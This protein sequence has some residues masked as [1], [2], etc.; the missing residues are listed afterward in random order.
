MLC[1]APSVPSSFPS[2]FSSE[3]HCRD[4]LLSL[5]TRM[6]PFDIDLL[7]VLDEDWQHALATGAVEGSRSRASFPIRFMNEEGTAPIRLTIRRSTRP[8][9]G[10]QWSLIL[11]DGDD[12]TGAAHEGIG[13]EGLPQVDEG[14][15]TD[16][17]APAQAPC[18][19][20]P[21]RAF[22]QFA[23]IGSWDGVL[24]TLARL[25]APERWGAPDDLKGRYQMLREYLATTFW[26]A[27]KQGRIAEVADAGFAAFDTGL[28]SSFQQDI[29][30][31]FEATPQGP[32]R[33]R[34]AGFAEAGAGTLGQ[35]LVGLVNPLPAPP[36]Y[37]SSLADIQPQ[38]GRL[39]SIDYRSIL[40][41]QTDRLPKAFL[42][43]HVE[44]TAAEAL[45]AAARDRSAT[46][47]ER[48]HARTE[49]G[50]ALV[51][52]STTWRHLCR[53]LD[54]AL[55]L[56]LIRARRS[57]RWC[58]PAYMP[59][60]DTLRLLVPLALVDVRTVDC[61]LVLELMPSGSYQ[62]SSVVTLPRACALARI[63]SSEMPSWLE[64]R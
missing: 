62:A 39:V 18:G 26:R 61:A 8:I 5:L 63:I 38:E 33:Y 25:A 14:A 34:L 16:L 31:C 15:W 2:R 28:V 54:D 21:E 4:E 44:G 43:E 51:S 36:T 42:E 6:L 3:V 52:D 12:G 29:Y 19:L 32:A 45:L 46:P 11:V 37:L 59:A 41:R 24:G 35:K 1:P 47:K 56:S 30:A 17:A 57:Y 58:A 50:H 55:E 48:A 9:A 7:Q 64:R 13:I 49:L 22:A 10:K 20:S 53:D 23:S 27:E 40:A 60:T